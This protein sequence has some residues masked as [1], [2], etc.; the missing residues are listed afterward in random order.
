MN[1]KLR[2]L[3]ATLLLLT[4]GISFSQTYNFKPYTE[5]EG[6]PQSYVYCISQTNKG[7]LLLSTGD[8]FSIFDGNKFRTSTIKDSLAE[9]FINT[10]FTDSR[11]ITWIGHFQNGVSY[12]KERNFF[13]LKGTDSLET[14][15]NSFAEDK[16]QNVWFGAKQKG[17]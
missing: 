5:D 4:A 14:K 2:I 8:G 10:H 13:K 3:F 12:M 9:T 7:F 16:E 6:L 1:N 15:I 17:L 11:G